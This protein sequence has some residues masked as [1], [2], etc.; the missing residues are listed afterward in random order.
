MKTLHALSLGYAGA[1]V[2]VLMM[3]AARRPRQL[4]IALSIYSIKI[5]LESL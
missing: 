2:A 3:L 1:V 4:S 5:L